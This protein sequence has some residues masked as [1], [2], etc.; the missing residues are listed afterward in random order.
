MRI[1]LDK[2]GENRTGSKIAVSL[3]IKK[4]SIEL[5]KQGEHRTG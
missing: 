4:V 1:E 3:N 5:D 2:E